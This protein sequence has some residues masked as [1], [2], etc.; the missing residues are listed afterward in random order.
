MSV[1]IVSLSPSVSPGVSKE[2]EVYVLDGELEVMCSTVLPEMSEDVIRELTD[3]ILKEVDP[4]ESGKVPLGKL[5]E[6]VDKTNV[7]QVKFNAVSFCNDGDWLERLRKLLSRYVNG[8]DGSSRS[9]YMT[10]FSRAVTLISIAGIVV[11]SEPFITLRLERSIYCPTYVVETFCVSWFI[12]E[13]CLKIVTSPFLLDLLFSPYIYI[14]LGSI[15]PPLLG[16]VTGLLTGDIGKFFSAIRIFRIFRL[17]NVGMGCHSIALMASAIQETLVSFMW[18]CFLLVIAV[19]LSGMLFFTV[20]SSVFSEAFLDENRAVWVRNNNSMYLDAG[21]RLEVQSASE[22][23]WWSLVTLLS[24]GYGDVVPYTIGGKIVGALVMMTAMMIVALS[25]TIFI[26][27]VRKVFDSSEERELNAKRLK[28]LRNRLHRHRKTSTAALRKQKAALPVFP[29]V[30]L[31]SPRPLVR[32]NI[33]YSLH[34]VKNS[35]KEAAE[36]ARILAEEI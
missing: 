1:S 19:L 27:R 31:T 35:Y 18:L 3:E 13:L 22:A 33:R 29:S 16:S 5:I 12:V 30:R 25:M 4:S 34:D 23:L 8:E 11:E 36:I 20:E 10:R 2:D 14:S 17:Y 9:I 6:Y 24:V 15:V 21:Q 32:D 7:Q 26:Q 28:S